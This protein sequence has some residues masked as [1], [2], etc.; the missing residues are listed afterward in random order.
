MIR[1]HNPKEDDKM[2]DKLDIRDRAKAL[3][4]RGMEA[5][6]NTAIAAISTG[7]AGAAFAAAGG[8][9][10]VAFSDIAPQKT[11]SISASGSL[12]M[13]IKLYVAVSSPQPV[14][15]YEYG[16]SK[17]YACDVTTTMSAQYGFTVCY[18][19]DTSSIA[20][21]TDPEREQI[22]TLLESGVYV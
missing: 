13:P 16:H 22:K 20:G 21:A 1:A 9:I 3:W 17:G 5:V 19:V 2:A 4:L 8:A 11:G 14:I 12:S 15:P 6:G 18:N 10:D 7:V